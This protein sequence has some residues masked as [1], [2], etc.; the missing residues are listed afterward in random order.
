MHGDIAAQAVNPGEIAVE[1]DGPVAV[2][3]DARRVVSVP[4]VKAWAGRILRY[5][6]WYVTRQQEGGAAVPDNVLAYRQAVRDASN[7]IEAMSPIPSD[8]RDPKYWPIA[9]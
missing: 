3:D 2:V 9:P 7:D 8:Y 4:D 1:E 5:T 6:D